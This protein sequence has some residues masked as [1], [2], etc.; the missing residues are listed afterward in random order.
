MKKFINYLKN[1]KGYSDG[2]IAIY[3]KYVKVL[4]DNNLDYLKAIKKYEHNANVT[5]RVVL[6][7]FKAYLKF[8]N[9][10][11][12]ILIVMP[13][14]E[15]KVKEF[16]T[17]DNFLKIINNINQATFLGFQKYL[18]LRILF[19]TG[20][21]SCELLKLEIKDIYEN[22]LKIHGKGKKERFVYLSNDLQNN[23]KKYIDQIKTKYLFNFSYKNLYQK[24]TRIKTNIRLTPHIL[25]R[26]FA[27]HCINN[28]INIYD[29]SLVM[30]H[31]NINSTSLYLNKESKLV[32]LDHLFD[33]K[34]VN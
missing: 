31:N 29:L 3:Q 11:D 2:T 30:G 19:E 1:V 10:K 25:R 7:A 16:L 13:K 32:E 26:S 24:V 4:I 22:K 15:I 27:N 33:N 8:I 18:I 6:S 9:H 34:K 20:I 14:K 12:A 5:K 28:G 23:I 17:W 21:R